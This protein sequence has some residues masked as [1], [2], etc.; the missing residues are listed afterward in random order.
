MRYIWKKLHRPKKIYTGAARG[1]LDKY[2]VCSW[3]EIYHPCL[4]CQKWRRQHSLLCL[5]P[6][7]HLMPVI[8]ERLRYNCYKINSPCPFISKSK[9]QRLGFKVPV[10]VKFVFFCK[11]QS[12]SEPNFQRKLFSMKQFRSIKHIWTDFKRP[13]VLC[14]TKYIFYIF[15]SVSLLEA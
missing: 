2:E 15:N 12:F 7:N 9:M 11:R 14:D 5:I 1:A 6:A 4:K 8:K 3:L 10:Q 13:K